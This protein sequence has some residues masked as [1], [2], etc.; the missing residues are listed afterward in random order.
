MKLTVRNKDTAPEV[1]FTL[2][3]EF[4]AQRHAEEGVAPTEVIGI[5]VGQFSQT[6]NSWDGWD[7]FALP[8]VDGI[9]LVKPEMPKD[10]VRVGAHN[11]MYSKADNAAVDL[12][13]YRIISLRAKIRIRRR[14]LVRR[15]GG[16]F[17]WQG[18]RER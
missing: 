2:P 17:L 10:Y 7:N 1:Y 15:A 4:F 5:S 13:S 18:I 14:A 9:P 11:E 12:S 3:Y 6:A 8:G 16:R